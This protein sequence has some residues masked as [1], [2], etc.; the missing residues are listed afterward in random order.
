MIVY[1]SFALD[2]KKY[3]IELPQTQTHSSNVS[4]LQMVDE[5]LNNHKAL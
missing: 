2:Y 1:N 3:N 4:R 5:I